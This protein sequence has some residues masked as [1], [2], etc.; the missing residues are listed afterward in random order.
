MSGEDG[1]RGGNSSPGPSAETKERICQTMLEAVGELGY[2]QTSVEDVL[3][4]GACGRNTFYRYFESK[5]DCFE[6]A[7]REEA[8]RLVSEMLAPCKFGW[9]WTKALIAAL[10]TMLDFAAEHPA[11]LQALLSVS[12][13]PESP[14]AAMRQQLFE[15]LSHALDRAR[16]LPGARHSAPPLTATLMIGA[17]ENLVRGMLVSGEAARAPSLLSDLTYL[18]VQSYFDDEAAFAAMDLANQS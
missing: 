8:G 6:T 17:V 16:R 5:D 10:G 3:S 18:V 13:I 15:R 2:W 4:R 7:Y 14:V 11:R 9:D 12:Q 1:G